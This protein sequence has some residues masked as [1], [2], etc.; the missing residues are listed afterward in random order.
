MSARFRKTYCQCGEPVRLNPVYCPHCGEKL[1]DVDGDEDELTA[2]TNAVRENEATASPEKRE[3]R[4]NQQQWG[5]FETNYQREKGISTE[6]SLQ[7]IERFQADGTAPAPAPKRAPTV[8]GAF[9]GKLQEALEKDDEEDEEGQDGAAPAG[10]KKG[11][12]TS[13]LLRRASR[14]LSR[15]LSGRPGSPSSPSDTRRKTAVQADFDRRLAGAGHG[16][17]DFFA[18]FKKREAQKFKP[19]YM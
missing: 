12:A 17:A 6:E 3:K 16:G 4:Y 18:N 13:G 10:Q 15:T 19:Q 2:V 9:R 1:R 14:R 8:G 5:L 11:G 7:E